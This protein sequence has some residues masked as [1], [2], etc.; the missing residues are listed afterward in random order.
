M[1]KK[2]NS[3]VP[4]FL[5][6]WFIHTRTQKVQLVASKKPSI[7]SKLLEK[8]L[9]GLVLLFIWCFGFVTVY[10]LLVTALSGGL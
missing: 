2:N 3:W 9:K 1:Y 8:A 5:A 6:A 7:I 10:T 4:A